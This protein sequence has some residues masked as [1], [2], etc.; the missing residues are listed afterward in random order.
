MTLTVAF[1]TAREDP[2]FD[3]F[4]DSLHRELEQL[5]G[6]IKTG[7]RPYRGLTLPEILFVDL[8]LDYRPEARRSELKKIVDGRF[9]YR[10][11]PP[12][13]SSW[14]GTHRLTKTDYFC[15]SSAR[16]TAFI[17]TATDYIACVDDLCILMPGFLLRVLMACLPRSVVAGAYF[18]V[19]D[20]VVD[21]GELVDWTQFEADSRWDLPRTE[22]SLVISGGGLYGTSFLVPM[23]MVE[24]VNGFDEY[25]DGVGAEDYELG[26]RLERA[27]CTIYYDSNMLSLYSR[28]HPAKSRAMNRRRKMHTTGE[29]TDHYML[30]RLVEDTTRYLPLG[31]WCN[32]KEQRRRV[33]AGLPIEHPLPDRDWVDG[34]PLAEL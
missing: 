27:G 9:E 11:V 2:C 33:K 4:C 16:N 12:K 18:N 25:C 3:W 10:H 14:Q 13:P 19:D 24:K 7:H 17:H 22:H 21:N 29:W 1:I 5:K 15:A 23:S 32:I 31:N 20:M 26:I 8:E 6:F 28:Q 34:Q 30:N